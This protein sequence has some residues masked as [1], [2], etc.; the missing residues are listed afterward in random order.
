MSA[1]IRVRNLTKSYGQVTAVQG[2]DFEVQA[3]E[4]FAMLGPNGAGKSTTVEVLEGLRHRDG[5]EVDVL[6]IDPAREPDRLKSNI[7]VALQS[8]GF[9]GKIR[10][11][12][13]VELYGKLYRTKPNTKDLLERFDLSDKARAYYETLSGGQQQKVALILAM[14]NNPTL[15]FLDEP[16]TGLDAHTRR[17]I[18]DW[19]RELRAQGRTVFLTT[20]YIH[21]AE[22]LADRVAILA[23]GRII[24]QGRVDEMSKGVDVHSQ[25]SIRTASALPE[26]AAASL[27]GVVACRTAN[28]NESRKAGTAAGGVAYQLTVQNP[29]DA[30]PSLVRYLDSTGNKLLAID[31]WRPTLE[32]LFLRLTGEHM[33]EGSSG[34][35]EAS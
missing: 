4:I 32:D 27:A 34:G 1:V 7:G 29:A 33:D 16:T 25:I 3:G 6:G 30:V 24:R 22:Q 35:N 26:A 8:T 2:I 12:E 11:V 17:K 19:L 20:H 28:G 5:G 31:I 15:V 18:H 23:R 10:V 14:I 13:L 21:E 9:P